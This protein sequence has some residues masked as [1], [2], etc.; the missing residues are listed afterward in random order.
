MIAICPN[1]YRGHNLALTEAVIRKL[2][3]K[4]YESCVCPVFC[5]GKQ[6]VLCGHKTVCLKEVLSSISHIIVIGGDGTILAVV[7]EMSGEPLPILG[8][9]LVTK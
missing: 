2:K 5:E 6:D 9:N 8:I 3:K 4:G 7:R 1:P